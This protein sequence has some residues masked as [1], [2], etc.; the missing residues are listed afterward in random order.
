MSH[1]LQCQCGTVRGFVAHTVIL[2]R[3]VCYCRDCQAFAHFLGR[4]ADVLDERGGTDVIQTLPQNVTITHGMESIACMRLTN[5]GLLRWFA[6]CCGTPI[7]N[8][9]SSP[10]ISFIGL[11]H[12]C[13][14]NP[15]VSLQAS[16]GPVRAWVNTAS[17]RGTPK[18][19]S[20]V[21]TSGIFRLMFQALKARINGNYKHNPFFRPDSG[22]PIATPRVLNSSELAS[23]MKAV[24]TRCAGI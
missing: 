12:T 14:E 6:G 2:N 23:L 7:G 1:P 8:T 13:L 24:A 10:N 16:F 3:G 18:P 22:L 20:V 9:L 17:A 5:K 4:E 21:L 19:K 15:D 11:V